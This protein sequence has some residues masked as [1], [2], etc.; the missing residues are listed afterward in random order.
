LSSLRTKMVTE[1]E[2][3]DIEIEDIILAMA[4]VRHRHAWRYWRG[5]DIC[6]A[7][8]NT[9]PHMHRYKHLKTEIENGTKRTHSRCDCG[10]SQMKVEAV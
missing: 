4:T 2:L 6:E 9:R 1:L 10:A 8:G 5:Q 7:C 3:C